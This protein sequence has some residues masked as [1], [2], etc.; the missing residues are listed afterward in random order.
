VRI[1]VGADHGGYTLKD[2]IVRHLRRAGHEVVDHGAHGPESV[3]YPDFAVIVA[4]DVAEGRAD[5]GVL[6]CGS[7]QGMAI[8]AN[9]VDG[10]RA[11]CV[12]EPVSARLVAEH[13]DARVLTLGARTVG[14]LVALACVDA[15]L[16]ARFEGGRHAGRV[17]KID[18]I[19][20]PG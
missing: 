10:V 16:D 6:V 4:L 3:D 20:K 9:K 8:A 2:D 11:A 12:S 14:P 5:R 7:G 1:S 13:N 19:G 18:A 17:V 15:W